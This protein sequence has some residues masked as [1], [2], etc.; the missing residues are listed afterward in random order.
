MKNYILAVAAT[1]LLSIPTITRAEDKPAAPGGATATGAEGRRG[2]GGP[3]GGR[4]GNPEERLKRMTEQLA[5]TEDQQAKIKAIFEKGA[6]AM[7]ALRPKEGEQPS[8]ETKAKFG[9]LMKA[10]REEIAAVLTPEQKEKA[11]K[12][13]AERGPGGEGRRPGGPGGPGGDRKTGEGKPEAK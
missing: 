10:Q 12:A 5:L 4:F 13:R 7:K 3:G 6:E 2:P 1:A 9:E 11:E 8:D